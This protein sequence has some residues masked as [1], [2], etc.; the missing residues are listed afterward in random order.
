MKKQHKPALDNESQLDK[1]LKL[2][3]K[4]SFIVFIGLFLSKILAYVYRIIIARYYGPE[5]YGL[6]SLALT[7]VGFF[8]AIA[9]FGLVDGITRFVP[10]LRA[11]NKKDDIK[12][13]LKYAL[14]FSLI[15][16]LIASIMLFL[17][18]E[19]IAVSI[20]HNPDLTVLIRFFSAMILLSLFN[21]IFLGMLRGFEEISSYSFIYNIFQNIARVGILIVLVLM[22]F[23]S[24]G[25]PVVL[26]FV[27]GTLL[28]MIVSFSFAKFKLKQIFGSYNRS[29]DYSSLRSEIFHYSWPIMFSSVISLLFYW[30][31]SFSL[32]FYKSATEV[33]FYNAAV[34]IAMLLGFVP[35]LF[36]QLFFP[37]INREYASKNHKL[38]EQLSKQV[39]KWIFMA[40][41]PIF[42]LIFFFPG[43]AL[44]IL[45][46]SQYI[47][48]QDALRILLAG[49][50]ISAIFAVCS[51]LIS[52]I[53][54]SKLIMFNLIIASMLNLILN[55]F[56]VPAHSLLGLDNSSGMIGAALATFIS[57]VLFNTLFLFQMKKYLK[58][59]PLR[60]SMIP[61]L[62]ISL[63][64]TI[65]LFY[66]RKSFE[67]NLLAIILIAALFFGL[68][69]LLLIVFKL[70]DVNDWMIIRAILR[71]ARILPP[72]SR[73][74]INETRDF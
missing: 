15:T 49:A 9:A 56:L 6:F 42:I 57:I 11:K 44:N 45:F 34:P 47:V 71:K 14:K 61:I 7:I 63:I 19:F 33:G 29:K 74:A 68:Y 32:G 50:F 30:I 59:M 65:I 60:R 17:S 21:N 35:E 73:E 40:I 55:T 62:L 53:G 22:G 52:M 26:S 24:G 70:L 27:L 4:T 20:F 37:M 1:S 43:A 41:L 31:D 46:G 54:K 23:S 25:S 66:L 5:V 67:M 39:T 51:N 72:V 12:Y 2:L 8:G 36:M 13:L 38:I 10:I 48:A 28:T 64:P 3:V 18:S 69:G 58:F 16:G